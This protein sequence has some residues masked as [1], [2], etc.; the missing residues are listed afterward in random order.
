MIHR[1]TR[2]LPSHMTQ[3]QTR[4]CIPSAAVDAHPIEH[5]TR[6]KTQ[7]KH[8]QHQ[9]AQMHQ[10]PTQ[11]STPHCKIHPL[12]KHRT[13]MDTQTEASIAS[14]QDQYRH[15]PLHTEDPDKRHPSTYQPPSPMSPAQETRQTA[16]TS[17][18]TQP[19]SR[20]S[21]PNDPTSE[22]RPNSMYSSKWTSA[23]SATGS[24]AAT[25]QQ[26]RH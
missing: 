5:S 17:T 16:Q 10:K 15:H 7:T 24:S 13:L 18:P 22:S 26:H 19:C 20:S 3:R 21:D 1:P 23:R 12:H 2:T 25:S 9:P 6:S 4:T 14:P 11:R 8:S